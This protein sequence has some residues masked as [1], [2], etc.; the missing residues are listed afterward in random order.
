MGTV[1]GWPAESQAQGTERGIA[2]A[3]LN[4][5]AAAGGGA[6][7]RS[8]KVGGWGCDPFADASRRSSES[9]ASGGG[10]GCPRGA[11]SQQGRFRSGRE[12]QSAVVSWAAS[13]RLGSKCGAD[14]LALT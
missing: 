7:R 10:H 11:T 6:R 1:L 13:L 4:A 8:A 2:A 3:M 14:T 9:A 5:A 12:G